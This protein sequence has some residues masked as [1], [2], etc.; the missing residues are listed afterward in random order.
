LVI[1]VGNC[2]FPIA[3]QAGLISEDDRCYPTADQLEWLE[4]NGFSLEELDLQVAQF[5]AQ[6]STPEEADEFWCQQIATIP[7]DPDA[8][9]S[10]PD[11]PT[12]PSSE[13]GVPE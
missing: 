10:T 13:G 5:Q 1:L 12:D 3:V 8:Q 4:N 9:I 11:I 7:T 2:S 6:G